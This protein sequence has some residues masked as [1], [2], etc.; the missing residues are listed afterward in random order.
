MSG[1]HGL[2]PKLP[3]LGP[4]DSGG[5][6]RAAGKDDPATKELVPYS[7]S[8]FQS[9]VLGGRGFKRAIAQVQLQQRNPDDPFKGDVVVTFYLDSQNN[10]AFRVDVSNIADITDPAAKELKAEFSSAI[11]RGIKATFDSDRLAAI[12]RDIELSPDQRLEFEVNL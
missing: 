5:G 10:P 3:Y 9:Q 12:R 8:R 6:A 4:P 1:I 2:G 7:Q 11:L